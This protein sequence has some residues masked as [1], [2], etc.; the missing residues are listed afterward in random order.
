MLADARDR[1]P[2][3]E[4][5]LSL[6]LPA[7]ERVFN[8]ATRSLRTIIQERDP[9]RRLHWNRLAIFVATEVYLEPDAVNEVARRL[10]PATRHLGL[11]KVIVRISVLDRAQA[12]GEAKALEIVITDNSDQIEISRRDPHSEPLEPAQEYERRVVEARSR[13]RVYPYEIIKMLTSGD[14]RVDGSGSGDGLP[15][16][17]FEEYDIEGGLDRPSAVSVKGRP[18][19]KNESSVVIGIITTPTEKVPE[20]MRRV[21]ILSQTRPWAWARSRRPS[22]TASS[23][24]WISRSD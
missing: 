16:G 15:R 1:S 23:Q 2:N 22:A 5:E 24:R 9:R 17:E 8:R 13:R 14:S 19:G 6:H 18:F 20:G 7:F 10:A 3:T 11:E 21:L 12:D 4:P